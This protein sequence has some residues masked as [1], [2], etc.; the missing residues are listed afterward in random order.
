MGLCHG[1]EGATRPRLKCR[2]CRRRQGVE[3]LENLLGYGSCRKGPNQT[4][5]LRFGSPCSGKVCRLYFPDAKTPRETELASS[6][7]AIANASSPVSAVW[8]PVF[9]YR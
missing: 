1:R 7:T 5:Y 8:F 2:K 6:Q 3:R 4:S 9:R